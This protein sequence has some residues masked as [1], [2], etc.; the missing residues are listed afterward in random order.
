MNQYAQTALPL[1]LPAIE[2]GLF[3]DNWRIRQSSVQ[4]LGDLLHRIV[5]KYPTEEDPGKIITQALGIEKRNI[6][7]AALYMIRSDVSS[8]VRQKALL[9]WK[10]VVTNTPRTLKEILPSLMLTLIDSL[11]SSNV[12]KRQVAGK[13]LGLFM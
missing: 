5:T 7:L 2:E 8:V 6:V 3:N 9:V 10:T 13:T 1:L 12:E 4:L 11:G